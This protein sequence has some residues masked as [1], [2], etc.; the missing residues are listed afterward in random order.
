MAFGSIRETVERWRGFG[1]EGRPSRG[2]HHTPVK[3][4]KQLR[5]PQPLFQKANM[6]ADRSVCDGEFRGGILE[7]R[8]AGC[9]FKGA[10]H[11]QRR[12]F[13]A[14]TRHRSRDFC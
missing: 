7:A 9:G 4:F 3:S 13:A 11:V 1:Q 6:P 14:V 12:Q 2:Q 8:K 5:W 10:D